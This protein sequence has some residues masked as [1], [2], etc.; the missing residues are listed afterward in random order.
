VTNRGDLDVIAITD[1]DRLSGS[2]WAY[3]HQDRY[4]FEIVPGMEVSSR[5]GH[6]LALWVTKPIAPDLSVQE[7]I[8]AIHEQ[9]GI[10]VLAHPFHIHMTFVARHAPGYLFN[11]QK[12]LNWG[13]D[14]LEVHNAGVLTPGSNRVARR[15]G[16]RMH[17]TVLGNSDAHTLGA[18]GSGSTLFPGRTAADL[19]AAIMNQQT[20]AQGTSWRAREYLTFIRDL[21]ERRGQRWTE[22]EADIEIE[23]EAPVARI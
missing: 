13:L 3:E 23:P 15:V 4:P 17:I 7:T 20:I 10:A 16:K 12:L 18:I 5:G 14:A 1:H 9:N 22:A 2:L 11:S 6:I 8:A 21:I 19:R